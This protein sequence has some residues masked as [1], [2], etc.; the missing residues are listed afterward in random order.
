MSGLL[1]LSLSLLLPQTIVGPLP[2][3]IANGQTEDATPVQANFQWIVNQV[4]ANAAQ[5]SLTPQLA[6]NNTFTG[7]NSGIAATALANFPI[8]SQIQN[9][10]FHLLGSVG[11][12]AGAITAS[13]TPTPNAY[14]AGQFF[15]FTPA[16]DNTSS[17]TINVNSLGALTIKWMNS[18]VPAA[19]MKANVPVILY[20]DGAAMHL[21]GNSSAVYAS[22]WSAKGTIAV[23]SAANAPGSLAVGANG[24]TLIADSAQ[25][26]GVKWGTNTPPNIQVFTGSGTYTPSAG[27][28][29]VIVFIVGGGGGGGGQGSGTGA[30]T[31]GGTSSFGALCSATGGGGGHDGGTSIAN[32]GGAGGA[33]SGGDLNFTGG[34][35][36]GG[37]SGA[38]GNGNG[39]GAGG[40]SFFGGGAQGGASTIAAGNYGAGGSGG[41]VAGSGNSGGG[42]GAGGC[43][44]RHLSAAS[45]SPTVSVTIGSGGGGGVGTASGGAGTAGVCMVIE[46]F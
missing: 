44:I 46:F 5:L 27:I 17:A 45:V 34:G 9:G 14:S 20:C 2:N 31:A 15:F 25:T 42:G 4:N 23:A 30:G 32:A 12:T 24:T 1:K 16:A 26:L 8:V 11:G 13:A 21:I 39:G 18:G 35:G 7:S 29:G 43:S 19:A 6:S 22:I 28:T 41:G 40:N 10:T 36:G 3:T 33:G 37:G 38:G